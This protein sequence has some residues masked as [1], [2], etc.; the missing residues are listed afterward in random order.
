MWAIGA[1]TAVAL[2]AG[3]AAAQPA[4]AQTIGD[5]RAPSHTAVPPAPIV[6]PAQPIA[7]P[8]DHPIF[9]GEVAS[10]D[11]QRMA[12]WVAASSDNRGLP[13][14]IVDK[15]N[16]KVFVFDAHSRV[17]GAAPALLGLGRGD[18]SVPGIGQR[19]LATMAPAER[20]TPAGRFEAALGNDL[21]QDV[22]WIDYG[23]ALSLHRVIVGKPSD[24]RRE[25]LASPTPLDNRITYGC[26]NVPVSFY[27]SVVVPAFK[28]TV[29]IVYILPETK[30]LG[31]V[32]AIDA[33]HAQPPR[34]GR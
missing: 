5:S 6:M 26:I 27:D 23:A 24:H 33:S 22:L 13:F 10:R 30:T 18:D 2:A 31:A 34:A 3:L 17:L 11:V 32:F 15:R 14:L 25:R 28:G 19:R 20:T 7:A 29:G 9:G 16:A 21:E 8:R 4:A 12:D 1:L